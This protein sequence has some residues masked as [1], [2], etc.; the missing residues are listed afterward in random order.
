MVRRDDAAA[1][2][3]ILA[4]DV[5][6]HSPILATPF[7]GRDA[8]AHLLSV[9]NGAVEDMRYT[10]EMTDGT[11]EA[12][13]FRDRIGGQEIQGTLLIEF[14]DDG[15]IR[16]IDVFLRP[17]RAIAAFM[18]ATGPQLAKSPAR[19]R[20][21]GL[22]AGPGGRGE[23][24]A[25]G[26]GPGAAGG[27][28]AATGAGRAGRLGRRRSGRRGRARTPRRRAG[29]PPFAGPRRP[30]ARP[31]RPLRAGPGRPG[32]A[33]DPAGSRRGSA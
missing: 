1:L 9:V 15:L 29:A 21:G 23:G 31:P 5:V 22:P 11:A 20:R 6:L 14:D 33:A 4:R 2:A 8:V 27:G 7:E 25:G 16:T 26:G 12:L 10:N 18:S 3:G 24:G 30:S 28:G 13:M 19:A 17:L 32:R